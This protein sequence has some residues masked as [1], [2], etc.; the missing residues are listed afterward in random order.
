MRC[1]VLLPA[2]NIAFMVVMLLVPACCKEL[3]FNCPYIHDAHVHNMTIRLP[4]TKVPAEGESHFCLNFRLPSDQE[5]HL[6]AVTPVV[7]NALALH[8]MGF[9]PCDY[10]VEETEKPEECLKG[11]TAEPDCN[12]FL[13]QW[14]RGMAGLCYDPRA[15]VRFG[16]GG[17]TVVRLQVHWKNS[18]LRDDWWDSPG[19]VLYYTAKLRQNNI[20]VFTAGQT[21]LAIPPAR[22]AWTATGACTSHCTRKVLT[23]PITLTQ[24]F[25]HMHGLGTRQNVA[26]RRGVSGPVEVLTEA[27]PFDNHNPMRRPDPPRTVRPGDE[28]SVT[29]TFQSLNRTTTATWGGGPGQEMCVAFVW[30]FPAENVALPGGYCEQWRDV[31]TCDL[32]KCEVR[33]QLNA[34]DPD[35]LRMMRKVLAHCDPAGTCREECPAVLAQVRAQFSC[36]AGQL[37][38]YA[39]YPLFASPAQDPVVYKWIAAIDSCKG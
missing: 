26:L 11:N 22:P 28:L 35:V 37:W 1:S 8:H 4:P 23:G 33:A 14:T 6:I 17:A 2:S 34:S 5:Y 19:M 13:A 12:M 39:K 7:D 9:G 18:E 29:C 15:G 38:D 24:V 27:N 31:S 21:S 30:F 3:E 20:G 25:H 32:E 16:H 36:V 10:S